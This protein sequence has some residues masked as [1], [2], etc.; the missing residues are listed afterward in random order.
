MRHYWSRITLSLFLSLVFVSCDKSDLF[1]SAVGQYQGTVLEKK[2]G[3]VKQSLVST[4]IKQIS[5]SELEIKDVLA[6]TG[7]THSF[8]V[9]AE[10]RSQIF[11]FPPNAVSER[12]HPGRCWPQ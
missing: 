10:N 9:Q 4:E 8:R 7:E 1:S 11:L 3:Q 6:D 12:P 2:S 5:S